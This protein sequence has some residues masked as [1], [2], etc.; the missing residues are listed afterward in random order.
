MAVDYFL[1]I[2]LYPPS[3]LIMLKHMSLFLVIYLKKD[4]IPKSTPL[5]YY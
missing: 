1:L 2:K 3:L 5:S 4:I